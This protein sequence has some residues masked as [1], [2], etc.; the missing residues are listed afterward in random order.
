MSLGLQISWYLSLVQAKWPLFSSSS[1]DSANMSSSAN[2]RKFCGISYQGRVD[3]QWKAASLERLKTGFRFPTGFIRIL[4]YEYKA[5]EIILISLTH[6]HWPLAW[7]NVV[8]KGISGR[9]RWELQRAFNWFL[10]FMIVNWAY[11]LLN[12]REFWFFFL[13]IVVCRSNA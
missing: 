12:N 6:L 3:L 11:L 13:F 4:T 1:S 8:N 2:I 10:N 7:E 9:K 5:E